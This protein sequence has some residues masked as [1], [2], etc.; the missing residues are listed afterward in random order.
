MTENVVELNGVSKRFTLGEAHHHLRDLVPALTRRML[1]GRACAVRAI[2]REFWALDDV[3]S[4]PRGEAFAIIG[5]NGAGKSTMLKTPVR[6]HAADA[7]NHARRGRL[8]ALI[9][10][11]AGFHPDLSGRDNIYLNG[12]IW[13]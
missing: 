5:G 2:P 1:R 11:S 6:N 3:V 12:A 13:E 4:V 10:I 8:S 7:G 9:E